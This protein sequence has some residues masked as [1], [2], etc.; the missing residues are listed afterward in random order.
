MKAGDFKRLVSA[1]NLMLAWNRVSTAGNFAY[2][3]YFR[4]VF[5]AYE[6]ASAHNIA[7]LH[8]RMN[9]GSFKPGTPRVY[10]CRKARG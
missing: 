3:R 9:G 5:Y 10:S 7:G 2:K 4:Q 1:D 6:F 8:A